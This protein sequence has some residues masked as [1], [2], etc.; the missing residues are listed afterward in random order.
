MR[1]IKTEVIE[2]TRTTS[3]HPKFAHVSRTDKTEKVIKKE[4]KVIVDSID[5]RYELAEYL[6]SKK[7]KQ[8]DGMFGEQKDFSVMASYN[9]GKPEEHYILLEFKNQKRYERLIQTVIEYGKAN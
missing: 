6:K 9:A 4:T 1:I 8:T 3:L 2:E 7:F 5:Q